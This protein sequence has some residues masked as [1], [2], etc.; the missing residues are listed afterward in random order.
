MSSTAKM[1][2]PTQKTNIDD[3]KF[4]IA[5]H[6]LIK[7]FSIKFLVFLA[8]QSPLATCSAIIK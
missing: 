2:L 5:I 4:K 1:K 7:P 6:Q 8:E 3:F